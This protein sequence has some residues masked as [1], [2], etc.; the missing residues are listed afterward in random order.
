MLY[1]CPAASARERQAE[2]SQSPPKKPLSC[3]EKTKYAFPF[4]QSL[5]IFV[6]TNLIIQLNPVYYETKTPISHGEHS[7]IARILPEST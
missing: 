5:R 3:R 2:R 4:L 6:A 7:P 1:N